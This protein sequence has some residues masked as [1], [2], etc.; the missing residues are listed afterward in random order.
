MTQLPSYCSDIR[1][2]LH[3]LQFSCEYYHIIFTSQIVRIQT[4]FLSLNHHICY[5]TLGLFLYWHILSANTHKLTVFRNCLVLTHL[6][7]L[8]MFISLSPFCKLRLRFIYKLNFHFSGNY[9]FEH[10]C[11]RASDYQR[12]RCREVGEFY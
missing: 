4:K 9:F 2:I 11:T 5:Y 3:D 6:F 1:D 8:N 7:S 12:E 10:L